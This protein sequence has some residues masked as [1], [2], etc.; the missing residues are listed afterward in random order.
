MSSTP[1][2]EE[3]SAEDHV[4]AAFESPENVDGSSNQEVDLSQAEEDTRIVD[5]LEEERERDL[6]N[7]P[8]SRPDAFHGYPNVQGSQAENDDGL[9]L[10]LR[11]TVSRSPSPAETLS[12][13]DDT[14]SPH[15]SFTSSHG[16]S[17]LTFGRSPTPSLRP[18]DRRFQSRIASSPLSTPRSISPAFL[19][20]HSRQSSSSGQLFRDQEDVETPT[21]P[22]EVVRWT[23]L[24][25]IS[26]QALSEIGKRSFGRPT[27]ISVFSSIAIGTS[28]GII[29]VFD[30]H[31]NLK[32]IIGQGSKAI[33]SGAVTSLAISA[34]QTTIASGH[35]NGNIFTW[36]LARSG[37]P[38]L[39]IPALDALHLSRQGHGHVSGVAVIHLGFLG[40]RHTALVS[41][42]DRGMAFSHLATRGFGAVSRTVKTTRILGRYPND[43]VN[44]DRPRKPSTVL[45]FSPLPLGNAEQPTD[46]M[47]LV[48]MLTPYLLVIVSTTPVAHT[49]HKAARPKEVTPHGALSGCL[50]WF[51]AVKLKSKGDGSPA[52]V[53]RAKLVYCWSNVL[54]VLDIS[55]GST[56]D[57]T[58]KDGP[59][60]LEFRARNRWKHDESIVAVQWLSRSVIGVLTVTQRLLIIEDGSLRVTESFDLIHRHI[61]HQDLFSQQLHDLVER[62]EDDDDNDNENDASMH[63]VIADA[64]YMSFKA[65]KGRI[66]LLGFDDVS[67]GTLSNWADRLL[68][69]MEN[70][71]FIGAIELATSYYTG[72]TDKLTVG[73]PEDDSL[74]HSVVKDKMLEMV[75]AS[76][77][78]AFGRNQEAGSEKI[79]RDQLER[80][81]SACFSACIFMMDTEFLFDSVY[82][83]YA[84]GSA[85]DI[86]LETLEPYVLERAISYVPPTVVKG[87]VSHYTSR[88]LGT[89][90]EEMI[91]HLDTATIDIDQITTLCK[92]HGLYDALTYVWNQALDDYITPLVELLSLLKPATSESKEANGIQER[93]MDEVNAIKLFPYLS[94]TLTGR[95]YPTAD[96]IPE[97]KSTS[98]KAQIYYFLFSGKS[99]SWPR[100][101]GHVILA[102]SEARS[103]LSFPYLR[104]ILS[105]DAPSLLSVLNEAFEDNFLNGTTSGLDDGDEPTRNSEED[106]ALGKSVNRQ[107][108][109]SMLLEVMSP[110]SF[111]PEDTIYLDMFLARN[112]PKFPQF[113]LLPGSA[114]TRVLVGL[115]NYPSPEVREDCQL[116]VEYL[117]SIYRPPDV[118][119]LIPQF[120]RAGFHRVLKSLYKAEKKYSELLETCFDDPEDRDNIYE[121]IEDCLRPRAGLTEKQIRQVRSVITKRARELGELDVIRTAKTIDTYAPDLHGTLLDGLVDDTQSQFLYLRTILEPSYG[122][123]EVPI[124]PA[125]LPQSEFIELYVRLMCEYDAFHVAD[126][127]GL[128]KAGELRLEQVLPAMEDYG[129]VDAAVVLLAREG[130]VQAAMERLSSHFTT[131]EAAL[132][133]L[134]NAFNGNGDSANKSDAASEVVDAVQKY[135]LVGIWLCQGQMKTSQQINGTQSTATNQSKSD[136]RELTTEETLWLELVDAVVRVTK[137][138]SAALPEETVESDYSIDGRSNHELR[139]ADILNS[140]RS[141]VQQTFT[142]LLR[143][144]ATR[145]SKERGRPDHSFLRILQAF[146]A[147]ASLASPSLSDLRT[148]LSTIF[149]AY[150]YEESLLSLANRLLD[151]DLFVQVAEANQ[152][153]QRGWKPR[154]PT[155]EGCGRRVWGPGVG[156]GIWKAW[157]EKRAEEERRKQASR[158]ERS[159]SSISQSRDRGKGRATVDRE[160]SPLRSAAQEPHPAEEGEKGNGIGHGEAGIAEDL[161]PLIVQSCGHVMHRVCFQRLTNRADEED[162][163]AGG[164]EHASRFDDG[165]SDFGCPACR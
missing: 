148:V 95:I 66:F 115:C 105:F 118:D 89:R 17:T 127:I 80:L 119:S 153:R 103:G 16:G 9:T 5:W 106:Q 51:P 134:C 86:F 133:G 146:L 32:S 10:P 41:A 163:Q 37:K 90:L 79:E 75:S 147:R 94:Y 140:L 145:G 165:H 98:A 69:L 143:S 45:A 60:N 14:P 26:G 152:L 91:C 73:L 144:T 112:L 126:Y 25:R 160:G 28:K 4:Q 111:P 123:A 24:K 81:A 54:T 2:E 71:D 59:P 142:A 44:L 21:S 42:D 3:A 52:A 48:A 76:L 31:Q 110:P 135:A 8:K 129:V 128:V 161:G 141:T 114:L 87:L 136:S 68:S 58:E 100:N 82:D 108:I 125:R 97:D 74:R 120:I 122:G 107:Y 13:P 151:R 155:C 130:Q 46:S 11:D 18:F 154:G 22:W 35:K 47:G 27:C 40:T 77:K 138:V 61:L 96:P 49:Q 156:G 102:T 67:V 99:I 20:S 39:Y 57:S 65:Y 162:D 132:L 29:L 34:D 23:R 139:P 92:R 121:C 101:S 15:G 38:F 164:G 50:A 55:E 1:T 30:Y 131:L 70:G 149:S 150:A 7:V 63:G 116:S 12:T 53:S 85:E 158:A 159:D 104:A 109:V 72:E 43:S 78:Y 124:G 137:N 64:F 88:G 157:Q 83:W 113:I 56:S 19:N 33:E 6:D 93:T 117:L 62:L 36:E 84:D